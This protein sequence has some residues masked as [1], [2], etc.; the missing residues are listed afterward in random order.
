MFFGRSSTGWSF[1]HTGFFSNHFSLCV[2]VCVL[3][4]RYLNVVDKKINSVWIF[5]RTKRVHVNVDCTH[6]NRDLYTHFTRTQNLTKWKEWKTKLTLKYRNDA[7]VWY[8][9]HAPTHSERE[10]DKKNSRLVS[11]Q[12]GT[13]VAHSHPRQRDTHKHLHNTLRTTNRHAQKKG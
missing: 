7:G 2:W 1:G 6:V 8:L 3:A 11:L 13:V 12:C 10:R 4:R 5:T 9:K